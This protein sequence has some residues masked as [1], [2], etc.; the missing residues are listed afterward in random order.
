MLD[1]RSRPCAYKAPGYSATRG[2]VASELSAEA[3]LD[4]LLH[5]SQSRFTA[6][7]SPS[8]L[9]LAFSDGRPRNE[10]AV[11]DSSAGAHGD[12]AMA[13]P[14]ARRDGRRQSNR[15]LPGDAPIRSSGLATAP[16]DLLTQA[17]LLGEEWWDSTYAVRAESTRTINVS[18]PSP[19]GNGSI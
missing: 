8:T 10:R 12:G 4:R 11:P 9:G 16:Y 15:I 6:G 19:C 17:V 13:A 1:K 3:N 18:L 2:E 5:A 7:R 14:C